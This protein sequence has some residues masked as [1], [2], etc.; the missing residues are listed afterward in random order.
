MLLKEVD[1]CLRDIYVG[2]ADVVF[3][4]ILCAVCGVDDIQDDSTESS[5]N[6]NLILACCNDNAAFF[7]ILYRFLLSNNCLENMEAWNQAR[8]ME[9]L[10]LET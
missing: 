1:L 6:D 3:G 7:I 4:D 9:E 2:Y 5:A 10:L 8:N